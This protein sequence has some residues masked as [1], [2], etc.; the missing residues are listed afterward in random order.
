[1]FKPESGSRGAAVRRYLVRCRVS[2]AAGECEAMSV[3]FLI[4]LPWSDI[5]SAF[6]CL[7]GNIPRRISRKQI[8]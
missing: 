6:S 3:R 8:R 5:L 7:S 2:I 1:M 4:A